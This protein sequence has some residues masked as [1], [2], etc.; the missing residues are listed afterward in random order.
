MIRK[1]AP[2]KYRVESKSGKN[3]DVPKSQARKRRLS[4]IEFFK[5]EKKKN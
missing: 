5:Q 4:L 1:L 2:K 3:S